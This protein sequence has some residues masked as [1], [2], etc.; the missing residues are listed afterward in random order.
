MVDH[1]T[2]KKLLGCGFNLHS[3]GKKRFYSRGLKINIKKSK[4]EADWP[5]TTN[6]SYCCFATESHLQEAGYE[7]LQW[8]QHSTSALSSSPLQRP[9]PLEVK[10]K[11]TRA[12]GPVLLSMWNTNPMWLQ[13]QSLLLLLIS[14]ICWTHFGLWLQFFET[15]PNY[16]SLTGLKFTL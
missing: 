12:A 16:V 9:G 14:V 1:S 5:Q 4:E 15:G 7:D 13:T 10:L 11:S 6:N 3:R 8:R 2:T